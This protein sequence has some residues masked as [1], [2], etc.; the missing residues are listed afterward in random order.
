[1]NYSSRYKLLYA[2]FTVG[3]TAAFFGYLKPIWPQNDDVAFLYFLTGALDGNPSWQVPFIQPLSSVPLR[4]LTAA[5]GKNGYTYFLL[6]V[7]WTSF[8][9]LTTSLVDRALTGR[10]PSKVLALLGVFLVQSIY[11]GTIL[12]LTFTKVAGLATV[13]TMLS[14]TLHSEKR[15]AFKPP[16]RLVHAFLLVFAISLRP[17]AG[18]LAVAITAPFWLRKSVW[19]AK[20]SPA[21]VIALTVGINRVAAN[22]KAPDF[23]SWETFDSA[24]GQLHGSRLF[25]N[26]SLKTLESVGWSELDKELF[27]SFL[28]FDSRKFGT[29]E[30]VSIGEGISSGWASI[31]AGLSFSDFS[32]AFEEVQTTLVVVALIVMTVFVFPGSRIRERSFVLPRILLLLGITI[33]VTSIMLKV[34]FPNRVEVIVT[35]GC[36]ATAMSVLL[37]GFAFDSWNRG[38]RSHPGSP[39]IR[40]TAF[41]GRVILALAVSCVAAAQLISL[42]DNALGKNVG[43]VSTRQARVDSRRAVLDL[44]EQREDEE[45]TLVMPGSDYRSARTYF[46]LEGIVPPRTISFGWPIGS[47]AWERRNE[48]L[49]VE[50][51]QALLSGIALGGEPLSLTILSSS[52]PS[53]LANYVLQETGVLPVQ[54]KLSC[55][56]P[57]AETRCLWKL[58]T[59]SQPKAP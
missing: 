34:R 24:R 40:Q 21:V 15:I 4:I 36:V 57:P 19:V 28:H 27:A 20:F 43:T 42:Y 3:I 1:M 37:D 14:W 17:T 59:V 30:L 22:L 53:L 50:V 10:T 54:T 39:L 32:L 8:W 49:G 35:F 52:A 26:S 46:S 13:A 12:T 23:R 6:G 45:I 44:L 25:S 2:L 29:S 33:V 58:S 31:A 11:F 9:L 18:L 5:F 16:L 7:L 47:P 55:A 41:H 56:R 48:M 51:R 38:V